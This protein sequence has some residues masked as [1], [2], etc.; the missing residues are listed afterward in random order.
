MNILILGASRGIGLEFV[1][2]YT[3]AGA[4]VTAT[5]R[6]DVG[7]QKI[8]ALGA[9][10]HKL[11][12]ADP[13]SVSGLAWMLDGEKFD[14]ALY[15]AGVYSESGASIPPTQ[16][17]FDRVMHANVLGAMQSIPQVAPLV[18]VAQGKF[19]FISSEMG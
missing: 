10:A 5:A 4:L 18:E 7:L 15:V 6:D 1:R 14:V 11:D 12:V 16:L 9:K 2:Q 3:R 19:I 8:K 17:E 13:Q